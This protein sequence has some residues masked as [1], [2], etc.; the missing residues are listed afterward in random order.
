VLELLELLAES[1]VPVLLA[2]LLACALTVLDGS[3]AG[4]GL[5]DFDR[6][7]YP[8][9]P[10]TIGL[11]ASHVKMEAITNSVVSVSGFAGKIKFLSYPNTYRI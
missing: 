5:A 9:C 8:L 7:S 1:S 10:L 4:S 6:P 3:V 2:A 11:S